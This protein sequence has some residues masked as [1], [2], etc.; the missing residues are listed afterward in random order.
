MNLT[1]QCQ[2][3]FMKWYDSNYKEIHHTNHLEGFDI[4]CIKNDI[5]I[6]QLKLIFFDSVK[7]YTH[8]YPRYF[9]ILTYYDN[10]C[11]ENKLEPD[12]YFENRILATDKCIYHCNKIYNSDKRNKRDR[13]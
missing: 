9:N 4:W 13:N 3:D 11:Y 6:N 10:S 2:K 7:I 12:R 8:I 5:L 1:G